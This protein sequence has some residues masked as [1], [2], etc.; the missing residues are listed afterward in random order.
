MLRDS[1]IHL[2]VDVARYA[3]F[4]RVLQALDDVLD[5]VGDVDNVAETIGLVTQQNIQLVVA[6][7]GGGLR[8][9]DSYAQAQLFTLGKERL[10]GVCIAFLY[11]ISFRSGCGRGCANMWVPGKIKSHNAP[12]LVQ[13]CQINRLFGDSVSARPVDGEQ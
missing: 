2:V 4:Q 1:G 3:Q 9:V 5:N 10:E 12:A 6:G 7:G 8:E 11:S 13:K